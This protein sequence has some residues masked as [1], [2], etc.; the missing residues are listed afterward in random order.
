MRSVT[1]AV[2]CAA[3]RSGGVR[4]QRDVLRGGQ[5]PGRTRRFN[6]SNVVL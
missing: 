5:K 2:L 1:A 6:H 4:R 3:S